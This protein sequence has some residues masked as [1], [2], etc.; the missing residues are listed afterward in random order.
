MESYQRLCASSDIVVV[1]GAGSSS[2]VNLR[3]GDIANMCFALEARVPVVL[4][5]DIDRGG[6]IASIVGSHI[7]ASDEERALLKGY[8]V[9]KFRGDPALFTPALDIIAD[10]TGLASLGVVGWFEKSALLPAEDAVVLERASRRES[11]AAKTKKIKISVISLPR[12]SNFDDFD[13]L[14]AES[15]VELSFV[16][17][18]EALRGDIN[19]VIIPGTKS[20]V[21]DLEFI[22]SQGWDT[23][24]AAHVRRGGSVL[25]ICGGYQIMG[26]EIRDPDAVETTDARTV[27]GLG[28]LDVITVMEPHKVLR[29]F[30]E[31]TQNGIAISGYE[32]HAGRTTGPSAERP[33]LIRNGVPEGATGADGLC[34]GCYIH[35]LFTSDDYR[36]RFLSAFRG[37]GDENSPSLRYESKVDEVLDDL[38]EHLERSLDIPKIARIS[39]LEV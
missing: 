10:R 14:A 6:A 4:V 36:A 37:G 2:E 12:I 7:L 3:D 13:P 34:L 23:D 18:G 35:G 29:K 32:I 24:I 28:L 27:Q 20:T 25:G 22:R 31:V 16:K 8:V 38:A 21:A 15:D 30:S 9:N 5:A 39:E 33:M 26:R 19:L 1:E 11:D 17:P